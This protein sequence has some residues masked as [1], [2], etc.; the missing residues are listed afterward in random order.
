MGSSVA[1]TL[2]VSTGD[3]AP[4][5]IILLFFDALFFRSDKATLHHFD[6]AGFSKHSFWIFV[7]YY[8][9]GEI[10]KC[11]EFKSSSRTLRTAML[12]KFFWLGF[13]C[14]SFSKAIRY[15]CLKLK[16]YFARGLIK[17]DEVLGEDAQSCSPFFN[18]I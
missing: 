3:H 13:F 7:R 15:S 4:A 2:I 18:S 6:P 11:R 12:T 16:C 9:I 1:I 14:C 10:K 8:S 5:F 17:P